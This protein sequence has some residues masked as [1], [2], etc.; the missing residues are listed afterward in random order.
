LTALFSL[1]QEQLD[2]DV[3]YLMENK[4]GRWIITEITATGEERKELPSWG[5]MFKK[6]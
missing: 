6:Q 1:E 3:Q 5:K 4:Q 2:Y